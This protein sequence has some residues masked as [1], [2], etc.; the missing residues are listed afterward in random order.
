MRYRDIYEWDE[1]DYHDEMEPENG[2]RWKPS[3][4]QLPPQILQEFEA[5]WPQILEECSSAL[6]SMVAAEKQARR[7]FLYRGVRNNPGHIIRAVS[8]T[9]RKP[10]A[11]SDTIHTF[12]DKWFDENGFKAKRSN[13]IFASSNETTAVNYAVKMDK[14]NDPAVILIIPTDAAAITWSPKVDDLYYY[15]PKY[16]GH[17][18]WLKAMNLADYKSS[19]LAGA[20][21]SKNEVMISGAYWAFDVRFRIFIRKKLGV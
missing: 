14:T 5:K 7:M 18:E 12:M 2:P 15:F 6:S 16:R 13:S 20:I 9:D 10:L 11:T 21:V 19:D 17:D 8:R 1:D 4:D 3:D